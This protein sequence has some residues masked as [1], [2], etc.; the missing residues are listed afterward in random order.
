[1]YFSFRDYD[2]AKRSGYS[3]Y[4][5]GN[6]YDS[7]IVSDIRFDANRKRITTYDNVSGTYNSWIGTNWNKTIKKEG[8]T[9][10]FGVTLSSSFSLLKGFSNGV[11]FDAKSVRFSPRANFTYEYGELLT[12]NPSYSLNYNETNYSNYVVKAATNVVHQF[13]IQT[14]NYWPKNWVFGNDFGYT[15]N[16]NIADGFKKDFYLWNT[17]LAYSF[18]NKKMTAKVKVYD[19]LNQNQSATRTISPT[20]ITDEQNTV[21]KRYMMFS[22]TYKIEKF[23]GKEKPSRGG[24]FMIF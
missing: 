19:L 5:G 10:K 12:I 16:S 6:Y 20:T 23:G 1:M 18:Y 11:Q 22:L 4:L 13:N 9:Y 14:T 17:S 15:F 7:Q 3:V 2:Y 8:N 21:L 24:R